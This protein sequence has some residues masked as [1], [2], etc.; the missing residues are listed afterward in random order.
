MV[1]TGMLPGKE[2]IC[3]DGDMRGQRGCRKF[4]QSSNVGLAGHSI[5]TGLEFSLE[6]LRGTNGA[7]WGKINGRNPRIYPFSHTFNGRLSS[8][9][10]VSGIQTRT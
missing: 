8:V 5:W 1:P 6:S 4:R 7:T 3:L 2:L 10:S 9:S